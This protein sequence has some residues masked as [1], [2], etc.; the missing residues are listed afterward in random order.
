[1]QANC[2]DIEVLLKVKIQ[3]KD[4]GMGVRE[5]IYNSDQD[6]QWKVYQLMPLIHLRHVRPEMRLPP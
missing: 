1:M 6:S 4:V 3:Y 5:T 2:K